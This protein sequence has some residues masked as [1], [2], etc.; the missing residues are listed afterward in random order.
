M[1][2]YP[3]ALTYT[4]KFLKIMEEVYK[5]NLNHSNLATSYNNMGLI[6]QDMGDYPNALAYAKK[7]LKIME[8]LFKKTYPKH[9]YLIGF[10]GNIAVIYRDMNNSEMYERYRLKYLEGQ[11]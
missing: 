5:D 1:G 10:Y 11:R 6:Y 8:K 4:K 3:N 7:A 2:D 9:P